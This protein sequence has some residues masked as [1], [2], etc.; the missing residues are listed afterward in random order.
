MAATEVEHV[1]WRFLHS[2]P[3]DLT[4]YIGS[5]LAGWF[6]VALVLVRGRNL[7]DPIRDPF[8]RLEF[9]G[10]SVPLTLGLLVASRRG[11]PERRTT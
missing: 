11:G 6:Y 9:L 5:S 7:S 4:W 3:V 10:L 8:A 2:G 1:R